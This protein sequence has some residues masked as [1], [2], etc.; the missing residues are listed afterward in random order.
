MNAFPKRWKEAAVKVSKNRKNLLPGKALLVRN[1][2]AL[3]G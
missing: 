3:G 1:G 2:F